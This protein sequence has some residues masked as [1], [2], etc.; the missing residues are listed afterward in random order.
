VVGI[1]N[2]NPVI[3]EGGVFPLSWPGKASARL[4]K[5]L[6]ANACRRAK[7]L[8]FPSRYAANEV[9]RRLPGG[10]DRRRVVHH[11]LDTEFWK[12]E[13]GAVHVERGKYLLF[14]S[15]F[16]A[17][18]RAP[19]LLEAFA[20]W[21]RRYGRED[22][23]LI[24]CGEERE[25][26]YAKEMQRRIGEVGLCGVVELRGVVGRAEL[27]ALCLGAA[28]LVLPTVME[29]FGFPYIEAMASET[30]L[31]CADIEVARELCGEAPYYFVP[32]DVESLTEALERALRQGHE[33]TAKL[34]LGSQLAKN[35]SWQREAR[36]TLACLREAAAAK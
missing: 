8:I 2:P 9:G 32:D 20:A 16:Y 24:Y 14:A 23:K 29:T 10:A 21:R 7:L 15:K 19:L 28:E 11:G 22:Y 3:L 13:A 12:E 5:A 4:H 26:L 25:S 17:Q 18:K 36:E 34:A 35:F 31:V 33:H 27:R 1:R 30:P 6:V